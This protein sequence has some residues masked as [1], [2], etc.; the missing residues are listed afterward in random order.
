MKITILTD[1]ERS[2]FIPYGNELCERLNL[3]GHK[4]RYVHR[5]NDI[6]E[7]DICFV[8]SCTRILGK[9]YL[10]LNR[11]NI[12][13]HASDLPH[14]KGFSPLQWQILEGKNDITLTLFEAVEKLDAG[15]YYLKSMIHFDGTELY[16]ELRRVLGEKII[17][18]AVYYVSNYDSLVPV[19][20]TGKE[21]IYPKRTI[22]DDELDIDKSLR[23]LFNHFRIA[24]NK[25]YPVFFRYREKKYFLKIYQESDSSRK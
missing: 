1:N 4:V 2:W 25:N 6:F 15:P 21:T 9:E 11:H 13:I 10:R 17:E 8:L 16:G 18:M 23:E 20:Q 14:G 19:H 22:K 5:I 3:L 7:G 12:V 24:D